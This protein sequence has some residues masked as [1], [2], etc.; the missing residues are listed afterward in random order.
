[1]TLDLAYLHVF[2]MATKVKIDA[3]NAAYSAALAAYGM[4][5]L[6]TKVKEHIDVVALALTYRFDQPNSFAGLPQRR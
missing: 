4:D 1:M 2:P 5:N 6:S 3:N